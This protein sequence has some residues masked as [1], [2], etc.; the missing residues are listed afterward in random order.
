VRHLFVKKIESASE[1]EI[2]PDTNDKGTPKWSPDGKSIA[3]WSH[4]NERG[5]VF[6]VRRGSD[7]KWK[8]LWK[9]PFGQLPQWSPDGREI[10]F[11]MLDGSVR[12]IPADSGAIRTLYAPRPN[13]MDPF[14]TYLS[15]KKPGS[16]WV[17]GN[18]GASQ[19][20]WELS[21]TT[22]QLRQVAV[23][24]DPAGKMI[25]PSFVATRDHFFFALNDRTS[26]VKWA[27][28]NH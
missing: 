24:D 7:G 12:I 18:S 13:S 26:N 4:N 23:V 14:A 28:L 9:L 1:E 27:E 5:T 2:V 20:I 17:L 16:I 25:G 10:A 22:G 21:L 6:V 8:T 11:V 19:G 3:A 15:W